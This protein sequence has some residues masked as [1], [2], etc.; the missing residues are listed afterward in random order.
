M[1]LESWGNSEQ[2]TKE[3]M[4]Y[5][6]SSYLQ[7]YASPLSLCICLCACGWILGKE[8]FRVEESVLHSA[9]RAEPKL[10][11]R[12]LLQAQMCRKRKNNLIS[13][14][15]AAFEMQTWIDFNLMCFFSLHL[16]SIWFTCQILGPIAAHLIL[17]GSR[18]SWSC[19]GVDCGVW[20]R[21]LLCLP[22]HRHILYCPEESQVTSQSTLARATNFQIL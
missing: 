3:K 10:D 22:W 2:V 17:S 20:H 19:F 21:E 13:C 6:H 4:L 16:W 11:K 15:G 14:L 8:A 5:F 12:S 9:F 1:L 7:F 18:L